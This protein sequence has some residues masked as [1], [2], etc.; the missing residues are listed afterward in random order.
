MHLHTSPATFWQFRALIVATWTDQFSW[1]FWQWFLQFLVCPGAPRCLFIGVYRQFYPWHP[2]CFPHRRHTASVAALPPWHPSCFPHCRHTAS[3]AA[4]P[5]WHPSCFPHRRHTASAA[6]LPPWHPSCFPHRRH[7]ASAATSPTRLWMRMHGSSQ[8]VH[9]T[10]LHAAGLL[11]LLTYLA[12]VTGRR[13]SGV[14]YMDRTKGL[15]L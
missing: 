11:L 1:Y 7:T 9:I 4:L 6:A 5:P 3:A 14:L 2:S 13:G 12:W 15:K 8:T 10:V